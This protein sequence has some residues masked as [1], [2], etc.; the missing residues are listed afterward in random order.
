MVLPGEAGRETPEPILP[1][2]E[3]STGLFNQQTY[4]DVEI[5]DPVEMEEH[6]L[7]EG[8]IFQGIADFLR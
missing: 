8:F 6:F 5:H 7:E 2:E 3:M 4:R 1:F